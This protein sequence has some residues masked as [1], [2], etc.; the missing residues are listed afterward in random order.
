MPWFLPLVLVFWFFGK[1][2]SEP[3]VEQVH[4]TTRLAMGTLVTVSTW[5]VKGPSE[6][7]AVDRVFTRISQI[8]SLASRQDK[9]SPVYKI[10]HAPT[11]KTWPVPEELATI[12]QKGLEIKKIS[13]GAF[14]PGLVFLLDLWG[15]ANGVP[16]VGKIPESQA[17]SSW[18]ENR[19]NHLEE[20]I[21]VE[22]SPDGTYTL[23][24]DDVSFAL[25]LGAIAKGYALD[26]AMETMKQAGVANALIIGGGD[27]VI[28]GSKGGKPWRIGIQHPRDHDK[29]MAFSEIVGDMSMATSGDYE[30]FFMVDGERQHH[31]LDPETGRPSRSGLISVSIQAKE[32]MLADALS[33]AVFVMGMEKGKAF[34]EKWEGIEGM[35][36]AENGE[37]WKSVGFKGQ[38]LDGP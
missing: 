1:K 18:L 21:R 13:H 20:G 16:D 32:G 35:L 4:S 37:R 12:V 5:G 34:I 33:T 29:I 2:P 11:K 19:K 28:A 7:K 3:S 22:K 24:L 36:V 25:D 38:W 27:M 26:K 14:D 10:N 30:R 6:E 31:I 23:Q 15:F 9:S 8:E 17:I